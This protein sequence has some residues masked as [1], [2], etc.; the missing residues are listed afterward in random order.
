MWDL[1]KVDA[2]NSKGTALEARRLIQQTRREQEY[3]QNL[4]A[5]VYGGKSTCMR[6]GADIKSTRKVIPPEGAANGAK[7]LSSA[8]CVASGERAQTYLD[9]QL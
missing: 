8:I 9:L 5:S 1:A 6:Y 4:D 3:T 2:V 7:R